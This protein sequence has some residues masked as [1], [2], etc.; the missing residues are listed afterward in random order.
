[1][2]E[3]KHH[4]CP[5][6][7]KT[8][9]SLPSRDSNIILTVLMRLKHGPHCSHATQNHHCPHTTRPISLLPSHDCNLAMSALIR[10]KQC[11]HCP[12]TTQTLPSQRKCHYCCSYTSITLPSLPLREHNANFT[13]SSLHS[14][15]RILIS[16]SYVSSSALGKLEHGSTELAPPRDMGVR[17]R[18]GGTENRPAKLGI[19]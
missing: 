2:L 12:H 8:L 18:F 13:M 16:S 4:Y 6:T 11:H 9:S 17:K 7:T 14:N 1:M 19:F 10:L 3:S 5:H 15:Q